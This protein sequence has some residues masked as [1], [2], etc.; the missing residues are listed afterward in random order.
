M[1]YLKIGID[2]SINSTGVCVIEPNGKITY[3][4][5]MPFWLTK[6]QP[7][8][9]I[10][11]DSVILKMYKRFYE[12][13]FDTN[14]EADLHKIYSATNQSDALI[15]IIIS[16]MSKDTLLD[17]RIEGASFASNAGRI[18]DLTIYYAEIK[19]R[20]LNFLPHGSKLSTIPPTKVKMVALGKGNGTAKKDLIEEY[21]KS[22]FGD[23]FDYSKG[24]NDDVIDAYLLA[25]SD[26]GADYLLINRLI[27]KS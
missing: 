6:K 1:K 3:Y 9:H 24:K 10:C 4:Q 19:R 17:V 20:L 8:S 26:Y 11:S 12:K 23:K 13:D 5:L 22:I 25:S 15:E 21:H 14:S 2:L 27:N 7:K 16:H 18:Y